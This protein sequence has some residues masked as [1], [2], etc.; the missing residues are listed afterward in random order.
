MEYFL[1][2]WSVIT[3]V[4]KRIGTKIQYADL[5]KEIGFSLAHIRDI[6]VKQTGRPL[7]AYILE[8]RISN[9][10]FEIAHTNKTLTT[11]AESYSFD[12]PDTFTRAFRRITGLTPSSFRKE[13]I[14]IGRI[15]LCAGVYG[16]GFT[17]NEIINLKGQHTHG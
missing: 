8:R 6:F 9:A 14:S 4:E 15:K 11:I 10:A 16:V 12:N 13:K 2:I 5:E 7:S 1:V 17:S 3:Y